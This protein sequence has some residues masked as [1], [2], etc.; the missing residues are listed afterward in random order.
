MA[1]EYMESFD[2]MTTAL[3]PRFFPSIN[4]TFTIGSGLTSG[5]SAALQC[6]ANSVSISLTSRSAYIFGFDFKCP[7]MG[8][9]F[10][11][12]M[13]GNSSLCSFS[14]GNTGTIQTE[15]GSST[16]A[17]IISGVV[18][19]LQ[20]KFVVSAT[21]GSLVVKADGATVINLTNIN[22]GSSNIDGFWFEKDGGSYGV[23]AYDTFWVLNT[24]GSHSNDFPNGR[25]SIVVR[26]PN[27]DGTYSDLTPNSGTNHYSRV[28]EN[29]SDDDVTYNSSDT[30]GAKDTYTIASL[31]TGYSQVHAVKVTA[32]IRKDDLDSRVVHIL[33]KSGSTLAESSDIDV[34]TAYTAKTLLLQDNP[35]TSSQWTV[36]GVNAMEPGLKIVS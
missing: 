20:I 36:S 11:R 24:L 17:P 5:S 6:S 8:G 34:S 32:M 21:A 29:T 13:H 12:I 23:F 16:E 26:L 25:P 9:V 2:L 18:I 15:Y 7:G 27:G 33:A 1:V 4:S 31:G 10:F 19:N 22:T 3:L 14:I 28:S 30:A 35:D